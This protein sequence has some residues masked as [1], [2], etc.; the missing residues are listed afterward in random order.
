MAER[1]SVEQVAHVARLSRLRLTGE[2]LERF[3]SQ[4]AAV[5]DH[6]ADVA[7]LDLEQVLPTSHPLPLVNVL[8]ADQPGPTLSQQEVLAAA[9]E[10]VD[11][12]FSVPSIL[13]EA[14]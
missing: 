10:A 2:E 14:P 9:P 1:I 4:M 5:L 11:G 8:R 6:A 13:A 3:A 12:R 7:S